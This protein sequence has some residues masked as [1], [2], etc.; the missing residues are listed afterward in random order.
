MNRKHARHTLTALAVPTLVAAVALPATAWAGSKPK[1]VKATCTALSGNA[2]TPPVTISGCSPAPNAPGS[3]TFTF[4]FAASGSS[5]ITWSNGATT[6]FSFSTKEI[7]PTKTT[8]K[9]TVANKKF[10][11]PAGDTVQADLKGKVTGNGSLPAGDTGLKGS[12][13]GTICVD[14]SFDVSLLAGTIFKL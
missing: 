2:V 5:T 8:S 12:V 13:K 11:C 10:K 9:G 6:S 7:D 14:A 4:P 3:G 1:P